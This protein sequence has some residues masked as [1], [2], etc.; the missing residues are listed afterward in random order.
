MRNQWVSRYPRRGQVK[1]AQQIP[2]YFVTGRRAI[3]PLN[4]SRIAWC[5]DTL[6]TW[7]RSYLTKNKG[8]WPCY[9]KAYIGRPRQELKSGYS[10]AWA[11]FFGA[12]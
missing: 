12:R 6:S 11:D 3:I 7:R 5:I 10:P 4:R 8:F 1:S 2:R 9:Y